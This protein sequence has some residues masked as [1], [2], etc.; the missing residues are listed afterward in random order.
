MR[1]V[2][3]HRYVAVWD[4]DEFII[5]TKES[6]LVTMMEGAHALAKEQGLQPTSYLASC[7]YYFDDQAEAVS[8]DLP[9]YLHLMR[10]VT[11]TIKMSPPRIFTKAIHD[12]SLA[13]G[14]HAHYALLTIKGPIDRSLDLYH[15]YPSTEAYLGHYRS[16]CQGEDQTECEEKYRPFLMRDTTMWKHRTTVTTRTTAVLE[17]LGLLP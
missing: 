15:L 5:P 13:L 8:E 2:S 14:L 6:S 4:M 17:S 11:R 7:T 9:E 10:H 1:H 16:K 3:T 12:T